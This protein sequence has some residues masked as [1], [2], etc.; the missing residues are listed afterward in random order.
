[1]RSLEPEIDYETQLGTCDLVEDMGH[2]RGDG[3]QNWQPEFDGPVDT[4]EGTAYHRA[5]ES[6]HPVI[7]S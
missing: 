5:W 1:M 2:L 3:C 7:R 4:E 6:K